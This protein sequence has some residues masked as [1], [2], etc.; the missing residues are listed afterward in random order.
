MNKGFSSIELIVIIIIALVTAFVLYETLKPNVKEEKIEVENV[1]DNTI[2]LEVRNYINAIEYK[3]M[4]SQ[5]DT[6]FDNDIKD[7]EYDTNNLIIDGFNYNG[8]IVIEKSKVSSLNV[9]INKDDKN[10]N[11]IYKNDNIEVKELTND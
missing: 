8:T 1:V 6:D 10:Y 5:V 3:I 2:E 9:M 11:V 7:G 4:I